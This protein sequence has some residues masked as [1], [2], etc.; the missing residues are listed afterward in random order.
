MSAPKDPSKYEVWKQKISIGHTGKPSGMLGK[1]H[2]EETRLAQ[3][4]NNIGKHSFKHTEEAIEKIREAGRRRKGCS[5]PFKGKTYAEIGRDPSPLAGI[6][7]PKEVIERI[8]ATKIKN[9]LAKNGKLYEERDSSFLYEFNRACKTRDNKICQHCGLKQKDI[10]KVGNQTK[11]YLHVHHIKP[12][13]DFP[14]LRFDVTNGITLCWECH[15][16][17]ENK[18]IAIPES[19]PKPERKS[20][21]GFS[22]KEYYGEEKAAVISTNLSKAHIGQVAWNKGLKTPGVGGRKPGG[23]PWNKEKNYDEIYGPDRAIQIKQE[24][25]ERAR[26]QKNRL[27][28]GK[29]KVEQLSSLTI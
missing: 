16:K 20:R 13:K 26:I 17:A 23:I 3:R 6:P 14:E 8:V 1:Q 15:L 10:V 19:M 11:D 4:I 18:Q 24:L 12:W 27:G 22:N 29:K 5:S 7:R 28:T 9:S 21:K 2:S 25:A